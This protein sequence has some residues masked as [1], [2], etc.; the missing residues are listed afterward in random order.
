M[1]LCLAG[2]A[3]AVQRE[4]FRKLWQDRVRRLLLDYADDPAVI[5]VSRV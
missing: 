5:R 1:R 3:S 4:E 2:Q